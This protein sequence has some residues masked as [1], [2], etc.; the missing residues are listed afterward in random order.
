MEILSLLLQIWLN[1]LATGR[2]HH[3]EFRS[4]STFLYVLLLNELYQ[5]E[6]AEL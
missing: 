6:E 3:A 4:N 5:I 1:K 2:L